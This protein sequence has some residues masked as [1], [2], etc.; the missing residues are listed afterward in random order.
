MESL[1]KKARECGFDAC[2]VVPVDVLSRERERLERWIGQGFHAGMNYMAN[3]I[4]KR[5]KPALL[6]EGACSVIVTLSN[7]YTPKLQSEGIPVV[8]RYAYGK[9]YHRQK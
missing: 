1:L 8:A 6:V 9:D 7:Y 5:E 4:E 2:G 3:N